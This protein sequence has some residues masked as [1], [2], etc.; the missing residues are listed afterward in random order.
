VGGGVG[1]GGGH[2]A[3]EGV[4]LGLLGLHEGSESDGCE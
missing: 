1:A 4:G 3:E 2:E